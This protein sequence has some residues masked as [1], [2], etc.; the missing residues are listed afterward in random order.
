MREANTMMQRI[1]VVTVVILCAL[2]SIAAAPLARVEPKSATQI[3]KVPEGATQPD[4]LVFANEPEGWSAGVAFEFDLESFPQKSTP[5]ARIQ[6]VDVTKLKVSRSGQKSSTGRG[7]FRATVKDAEG[8]PV[9][10]GTAAVKPAGIPLPY[11]I[12]VTEAVSAALSKPAGQRKVHIELEMTGAPAYY[13]VYG[14][15]TGAAAKAQPAL[16]IAPDANWT[17]DWAERVAPIDRGPLVYREACM[18]IAKSKDAELELKLLYPA[19]RVVEVIH[20]GTGEKLQEGRDWVLRE[21]KVFLPPGSHAPV[22]VEAEFFARPPSTQPNTSG[23]PLPLLTVQLKE[24]TYYHER[25]IEV[26]YEPS[27]RDGWSM[28]APV[29]SPDKLPRVRKM[30]AE[31]QPVRVVLLGDSITLGG[32]ASRFQGGWPYQPQYGELAMWAIQ[33]HYGGPLEIINPSRGGAGAL[34]G[35]TQAESQA[36]WFKPDLVVIG[37]GMNDRGDKR[38]PTYKTDLE[39]IIDNIRKV[40][41]DTEFILVTSMMNNPKQPTGTEPIFAL[42]DMALAIDRTGLAFADMTTTHQKLIE[43]KNYLDTSGNGANHPNDY[44]HRIYAQ[45]V[46]ELLK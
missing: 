44:L 30:L 21:G 6:L 31:K 40:S 33:K 39:A 3:G 41:P 29:S 24:G 34:F 46:I 17:N 38:R 8:K 32:N 5:L 11:M 37:Y 9:T 43:R 12:D 22:Q 19:K 10:V 18:P 36:G 25:Q 28:P 23:K 35:S 2:C 45:R 1:R 13:E 15:A 4:T 14:L 27:S 26:T 42:R 20:L 16:E 7:V